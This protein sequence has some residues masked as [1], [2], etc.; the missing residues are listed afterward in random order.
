MAAKHPPPWVT[1]ESAL[2]EA[3]H[4]VGRRGAPA[5][6]TLLRRRSLNVGF[7]VAAHREPVL[8]LMEKYADQPASLADASIVRMT[9]VLAEPRVLTT[10]GDFGVYRRHGR[11][12]VPCERPRSTGV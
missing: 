5:L 7:D 6:A 12:A 3:F 4:L 9:E 1:C 10:D 11:Q 2:S 8:A